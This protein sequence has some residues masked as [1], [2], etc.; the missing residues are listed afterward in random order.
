MAAKTIFY[1]QWYNRKKRCNERLLIIPPDENEANW[2]N[3]TYEEIPETTLFDP[4]G[5]SSAFDELPQSLIDTPTMTIQLNSNK[6]PDKLKGY[7]LSTSNIMYYGVPL[8]NTWVLLTDNGTD[9]TTW[10][11][12]FIGVQRKIPGPE[13]IIHK[14]FRYVKVAQ[15]YVDASYSLEKIKF[16]SVT[17]TI[18][19]NELLVVQCSDKINKMQRL[20]WNPTPEEV[21]VLFPFTASIGSVSE[22]VSIYR[23]EKK[24]STIKVVLLDIGRAI[25][26]NINPNIITTLS[27]LL[28]I[29][30]KDNDGL[31][32]LFGTHS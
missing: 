29:S 3:E 17:R 23:L 5:F 6:I 19:S 10:S 9:G 28:D 14:G 11:T 21:T 30:P 22:P 12:K 27:N 24:S 26:E 8:T 4:H 1:K 31:P 16:T 25:L 15:G 32:P 2:G 7:I 18:S 13:L 20:V